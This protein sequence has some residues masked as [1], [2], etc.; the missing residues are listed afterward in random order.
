MREVV[1]QIDTGNLIGVSSVV[2]LVEVLALPLR[3]GNEG[4]ANQ[5]HR[6]F[7]QSRHFKLYPITVES[8]ERAA[9]LRARYS[10]RTPDALQLAVA[11]EAG[12]EAFL[13]NDRQLQRVSEVRVLLLNELEL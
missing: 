5:Y 9:V 13:T 2:T 11:I 8:A 10:L 7:E 12:C 4:L 6:L 3:Q 1:A